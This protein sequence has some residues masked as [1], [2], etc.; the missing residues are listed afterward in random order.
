MAENVEYGEAQVETNI[1]SANYATLENLVEIGTQIYK[2]ILNYCKKDEKKPEKPKIQEEVSKLSRLISRHHVV[3]KKPKVKHEEETIDLEST[4]YRKVVSMLQ[5]KYKDFNTSFPIFIRW[6]VQTG[7]FDASALREFLRKHA[8]TGLKSMED[9]LQLQTKYVVYLYQAKHP[10]WDTRKVV[11]LGSQLMEALIKEEK[12]F[13]EAA[14][15][16]EKEMEADKKAATL[17]MR[18]KII[19]LL[20]DRAE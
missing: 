1:V 6:T 19:Q 10:H 5:K 7:D 13:K 20:K 11:E 3:E 18:E 4:E 2:E 16:V 9:F 14:D 12:E 17:F 15:E 8:S